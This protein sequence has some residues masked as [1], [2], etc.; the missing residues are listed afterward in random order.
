MKDKKI[1]TINEETF[2]PKDLNSMMDKYQVHYVP[3]LDVAI[4]V[5]DKEAV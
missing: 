3:L 1:F 5:D 4:A 2:P